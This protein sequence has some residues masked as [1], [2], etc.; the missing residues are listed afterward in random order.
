MGME[1]NQAPVTAIAAGV[2]AGDVLSASQVNLIYSSALFSINVAVFDT[3]LEVQ[4]IAD[5][6]LSDG[7]IFS[8]AA[9]ITGTGTWL[10][11]VGVGVTD[12]SGLVGSDFIIGAAIPLPRNFF[13]K[14]N[15]GGVNNSFGV[16]YF[17][18]I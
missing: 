16:E 10:W 2:H 3:S 4:V 13:V 9:V 8:D 1:L 6:A 15:V 17:L 12:L 7:V 14:V 5:G 18:V 11:A